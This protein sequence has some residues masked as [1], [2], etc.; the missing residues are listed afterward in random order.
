M[1]RGTIVA[2]GPEGFYTVRIDTGTERVQEQIAA[3][4]ARVA[5]MT[6][7]LAEAEAA[8]V[9][10]RAEEAEARAQAIARLNEYITAIQANPQS[11]ARQ[12]LEAYQRALANLSKVTTGRRTIELQRDTIRLEVAALQLRVERLQAITTEHVVPAWCADLTE[13][14][15]GQVAT[16]EVPGER[17]LLLVAPGGRAPAA[18]DGFLLDRA[19]QSPEQ[20]FWNA[21]VLPG[22]QRFRPDYRAGT[23]TSKDDDANVVSVALDPA[24]SSAQDLDVNQAEHLSGVPVTYLTCN[25]RAFEVGDRCI[26][27]FEGRD[28]AQPRVI[29]FVSNPKPCTPEFP[30]YIDFIVGFDFFSIV[31]FGSGLYRIVYA[32]WEATGVE[33]P[34]ETEP[35]FSTG[36]AFPLEVFKTTDFKN[37]EQ[38]APDSWHFLSTGA[39]YFVDPPTAS[40]RYNDGD[41][42]ES[43]EGVYT[44]ATTD[45]TTSVG[46]FLAVMALPSEA[47]L[48]YPATGA[49]RFY[50]RT[51][52]YTL[53]GGSVETI[54]V[55]YTLRP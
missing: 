27:Q 10:A 26:V 51:S 22:W 24:T 30:P 8:L 34:P 25:S 50:D 1:G 32:R 11:G 3:A 14:A 44:G 29:G 45:H 39:Y 17:G 42:T 40:L 35:G 46:S 4:E 38:T 20:V 21:A 47:T 5:Q 16:I 13:T 18:A 41:V 9:V 15:A 12:Q 55:R 52:S 36:I 37:R 49:S 6:A 7:S 28:W 48:S 43:P 31:D 33:F 2:G 19:A 54:H 53:P 23:I